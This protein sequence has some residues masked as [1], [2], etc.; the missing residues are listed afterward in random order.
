[1]SKSKSKQNIKPQFAEQENGLLTCMGTRHWEDISQLFAVLIFT[2]FPLLM[3]TQKYGNVTEDKFRIFVWA[4]VIFAVAILFV[5]IKTFKGK[6]SVIIEDRT[7]LQPLTLPQL[8]IL[9]YMLWNVISAV[10]SSYGQQTIIGMSRKEGL[11]SVLL[12]GIVFLLLSY[13]GEYTNLYVYGLGIMATILG[14]I[15]FLQSLGST[16]IYPE[17]YTYWNSSFLSTIGHEDV[18]S[19]FVSI[20]VPALIAGFALLES[21]WR[22]LALPGIFFISY[23]Q[24]FSDVDSGKLGLLAAAVVLVPLLCTTAKNIARTLQAMSVLTFAA[25]INAFYACKPNKGPSVPQ[26]GKKALVFLAAA[27]VFAVIGIIL[28]KR[29]TEFKISPIK[30]RRILVIIMVAA[31]IAGLAFV[32]TYSGGNRLLKEASEILHGN[33]SDTAGSVRGYIWKS[34]LEI[35]KNNPMGSGPGTFKGQFEPYNAGYQ[36]YAANTIV[37]FAHNDFLQIM[38][39]TGIIGIVLYVAFIVSLLFRAFKAEKNSPLIIIMI[40]SVVGYLAHSFF[41]FSIAIITPLFWVMAGVLDK[42][43]RQAGIVGLQFEKK[44]ESMNG[45]NAE[46]E[47]AAS[48]I[49]SDATPIVY[50]DTDLNQTEQPLKAESSAAKTQNKKPANKMQGKAKK[51]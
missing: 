5:F 21:K 51:K 33:M 38:V 18:V 2:V 20:C 49:H 27:I 39:C 11:I 34:A 3:G 8:L 46:A 17:G 42:L 29:R 32:Y 19:G 26:M 9:A 36:Q 14:F 48:E 45:K 28:E 7:R 16:I 50:K 13:W 24:F 22:F 35:F 23:T 37:D 47:Q 43:C 10:M 25:F 40:G 6:K 30:L 12:Y 1:M 31:I 44:A 4:S 41:S 15:A